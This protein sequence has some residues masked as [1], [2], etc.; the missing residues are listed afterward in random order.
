M[1]KV[2]IKYVL[3]HLISMEKKTMAIMIAI[4][5]VLSVLPAFQ[6]SAHTPARSAHA[7]RS[8]SPAI[9]SGY[10]DLQN[11]TFNGSQGLKGMPGL[12][13]FPPMGGFLKGT[14]FGGI[15]PSSL[16]SGVMPSGQ[17]NNGAFG[18]IG[19]QPLLSSDNSYMN[20]AMLEKYHSLVNNGSIPLNYVYLPN[21]NLHPQVNG[22]NVSPL[23]TS[24]PAPMGIGYFG[25][26]NNSGTITA[27]TVN[28]SSYTGTV[29]INN[30][31][32]FYPLSG[33]PTSFGIQLNTVMSNVTIKGNGSYVFWTQDVAMYSPTTHELTL[34]DNIWNFSASQYYGI[35]SGTL[36]G[37]G[38]DYNNFFYYDVGPTFTVNLPFKLSL[39]MYSGLQ[40]GKS[41]VYFNYSIKSG[42]GT[43]S[44]S[45]DHV[46]FNS[47]QSSVTP[48]FE[49]SGSRLT[50]LGLLYD[51]E[52]MIGG[53][54]GGSTTSVYAMNGT[55]SLQYYSQSNG[56][57]LNVPSAYD[58]G[59][60]TGET[61][62][63]GVTD[64][65]VELKRT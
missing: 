21:F 45:Y 14:H 3:T 52:L 13:N 50:P 40:S 20:S 54:G 61:S 36:S 39:S 53:P 15:T 37:N 55:M 46:L 65:W 62:K 17:W 30:I 31:N 49:V 11:P 33:S 57:F 7:S 10:P 24:Y 19:H 59:T 2:S 4:L 64:D 35:P 51:S 34:I 38:T 44:G 63:C 8:G 23:Y 29:D 58:Y 9:S 6:T 60:D 42:A 47:T 43:Q 22:N 5:M 56:K 18:Q 1:R 25:L 12:S 41:S 16:G 26:S 32:T 27:S 28:S 48:H